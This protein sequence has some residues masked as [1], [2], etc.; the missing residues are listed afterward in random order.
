MLVNY[1]YPGSQQAPVTDPE[2]DQVALAA[3]LNTGMDIQVPRPVLLVHGILGDPAGS[4]GE[5]EALLRLDPAVKSQLFQTAHRAWPA[6]AV[7]YGPPLVHISR[8]HAQNASALNTGVAGFQATFSQHLPQATPMHVAAHSMGGL[9]M[10]AWLHQYNQG[11]AVDRVVTLGTPHA[12]ALLALGLHGN[13][14]IPLAVQQMDPMW[15]LST[16]QS[17]FTQTGGARFVLVGSGVNHSANLPEVYGLVGVPQDDDGLVST[18]SSVFY[19]TYLLP[20]LMPSGVHYTPDQHQELHSNTPNGTL[21]NVLLPA[22]E[23]L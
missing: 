23:E 22:L 10:R 2:D 4:W 8:S 6:K 3:G 14:F 18:V 12:G 21:N 15:V 7:T 1:R 13:P 20:S 5:G 19:P 16:F 9:V 11:G 17:Q